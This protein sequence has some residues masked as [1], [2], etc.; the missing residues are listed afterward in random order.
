M[1]LNVR[2]GREL[3]R[4]I[5]P[6]DFGEIDLPHSHHAPLC[7]PRLVNPPEHPPSKYSHRATIL[8]S[9]S[10]AS[11]ST[12]PLHSFMRRACSLF[13]VV[14]SNDTRT[15]KKATPR[16]LHSALFSSRLFVSPTL[17]VIRT[18]LDPSLLHHPTTHTAV[19]KEESTNVRVPYASSLHS[20]P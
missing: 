16:Q 10:R 18:S 13:T 4:I 11:L 5:A 19:D 20:T 7:L 9:I 6:C 15:Q 3:F 2:V 14:N 17:N 8:L 1:I 12:L